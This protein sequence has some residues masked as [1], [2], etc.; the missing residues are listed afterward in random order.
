MIAAIGLLFVISSTVIKAQ[1]PEWTTKIHND[2]PRLFFNADTWPAVRQRALSAER[3]WY[4]N[5]KGRADKLL[6]ERINKT[7]SRELGPQAAWAAFVFRVTQDP[8]YLNLSNKCLETSLNFY[9]AC[10]KQ[11]K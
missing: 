4:S 3:D 10:F 8:K 7:Q 2:H 9:E 1:L 5:I 6:T 11:R